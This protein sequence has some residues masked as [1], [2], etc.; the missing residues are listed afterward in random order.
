MIND[1]TTDDVKIMT[2]MDEY[3]EFKE[4]ITT[5]EGVKRVYICIWWAWNGFFFVW[6]KFVYIWVE[7]DGPVWAAIVGRGGGGL[8]YA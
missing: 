2:H 7:Y 1:I 4:F 3:L 6:K 8:E 5:S